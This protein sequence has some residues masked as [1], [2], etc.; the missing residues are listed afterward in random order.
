MAELVADCPRCRAARTTFDLRYSHV[1]RS[2]DR[3]PLEFEA[4]CICRHCKKGTMFVLLQNSAGSLATQ[5]FN[6][7]LHK[8]NGS[9]NRFVSVVQYIS[10]KDAAAAPPPEHLP[11]EIEAAFREGA[12][13]AAINCHNAAAAM[14]RLCIDHATSSLLPENGTDGLNGKIR[15]SLGLRLQWLLDHHRLPEALRDLSEAV[16]E[17]GNDGAHEGTLT[18]AEAD[19]LQDFTIALLERLYTEPQKLKLAKERRDARRAARPA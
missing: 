15:R 12:S 2:T 8:Y 1:T 17:D 4:Y 11:A 19:D 16:K 5:A 6:E 18:K 9:A 14:Y 13:C 10:V 7:G 3:E